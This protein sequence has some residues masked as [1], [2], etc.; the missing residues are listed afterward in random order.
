MRRFNLPRWL[1]PGMHIKRWLLLLFAGIVILGLGGAVFLYD[2]YRVW[3]LDE[4]PF[5]YYVTGAW[6]ERPV[7]AAILAGGGLVLTAIGMWGLMRSVLS[8]FVTRG[9]SVLEVLY[10]KRYLARGPRIVALG[11]G[12][13]LDAGFGRK[14]RGL[15]VTADDLPDY[16][17]KVVRNYLDGR[18]PGERFAQ[19]AT[20]A[21]EEVLSA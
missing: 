4:V 20:R 5:F 3:E 14:L 21:E 15:K 12:T 13:G 9:G 8:P 17:E 7:R 1:Y 6:L 19:W 18:K 2:V 10:T 11:G 16:V